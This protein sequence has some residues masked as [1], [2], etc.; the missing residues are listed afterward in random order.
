MIP[1]PGGY[2]QLTLADGE[3]YRY[4]VSG[5]IDPCNPGTDLA[6]GS[7]P[8][9]SNSPTTNQQW[10]A[11]IQNL[12]DEQHSGQSGGSGQTGGSGGLS[13]QCAVFGAAGAVLGYGSGPA[14]ARGIGIFFDFDP[15]KLLTALGWRIVGG[16]VGAALGCKAPI[17]SP[18]P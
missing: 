3:T 14:V 1:V 5:G 15:E 6:S 16:S 17:G 18:F 9:Q 12:I 11:Y 2:Y 7:A 13:L 10:N 8:T 4:T